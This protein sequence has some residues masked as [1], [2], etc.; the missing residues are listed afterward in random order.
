MA[1]LS[2]NKELLVLNGV[3]DFNVRLNKNTFRVNEK[4]DFILE[5]DAGTISFFSGETGRDYEF[6]N[7]RVVEAGDLKLSFQSAVSGGAQANQF[8][9]W[10][11][12]D[13][14]G[15]Y[16]NYG[17]IQNGNWE[18]ITDRFVWGT[19]GTFVAS[20]NQNLSDLKKPGKRLYLAFKYHTKP[21][22]AN[23]AARSWMVQSFSLTTA[24]SIGNLV[25]ADMNNVGFHIIDQDSAQAVSRSSTSATRLTML[26]NTFTAAADPELTTWAITAPFEVNNFDNGPDRAVGIKAPLEAP[27]A[28]YSYSYTTPGTYKAIFIASNHNVYGG[29]QVAKEITVTITP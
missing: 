20:G 6:R 16:N 4:I 22:A 19:T 12:S 11:S 9:L 25:V 14:N 18:N 1:I 23:G 26:G 17:S 13:F 8:S 10:A 24:S 5:G 15:Q 21:Q 7:G 27:K 2:C 29:H 28:S 3:P